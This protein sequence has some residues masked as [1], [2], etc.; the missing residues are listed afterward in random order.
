MTSGKFSSVEIS[1]ITVNRDAR[2]RRE[3]TGIED[4]ADSLNRVGQ[5]HPIVIT[6]EY[7][8]VAGERR[9]TA[10]K[11]NGWA[12]INAQF[13]YQLDSQELRA[14]ELEENVKRKDI[15]WQDQVQAVREYHE[16]QASSDRE[17][18]IE[19]TAD[20]L[21]LSEAWVY[22]NI[23][24]AKALD[25]NPDLAAAP[26]LSTAA[27]IVSRE[28][29]R[30]EASAV[31]DIAATI[32]GLATPK[33][34]SE[35]II[36]TS[37]LDWA[38]TYDGLPFNFI[39][40][41]FPYG[42]NAN[43][44]QQGTSVVSHGTYDD[45]PEVYWNLLRCFADN[46]DRFCAESAHI[47][48]WFSMKYYEETIGF[49]RT[50]TDFIIDDFPLIWTKSDNIGLLPEPNYGPRRIYETALFGRRGNRPIVSAVSNSKSL[51]SVRDAHMSEKNEDMLKHFFQMFVD[52]HSRVLDPTCG[53]GSAI[54]AAKAMGAKS[55]LGLEINPEYAKR[56]MIK[57]AGK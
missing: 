57:L 45:S 1:R 12:N 44:M 28:K 15:P 16:I 14:I 54:R 6:E 24:V 4:L 5:I 19:K 17:W 26:K 53:S 37:F 42:I 51:P 22:T 35:T 21:G 50:E 18:S 41:D 38:P 46:L 29:Q 47:M 27:N 56:A 34:E 8:L 23:N 32:G 10:A 11:H 31:D 2:Q 55:A 36:N 52:K 20:A 49:L 39:H 33:I 13:T 9:L 7:V 43:K 25:I 3:L 40:C 30:R 48:F